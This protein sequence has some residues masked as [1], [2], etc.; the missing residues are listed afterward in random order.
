MVMDCDDIRLH[1]NTH[2]MTMCPGGGTGLAV[3]PRLGV[4]VVAS[5]RHVLRVYKLEGGPEGMPLLD[6]LGHDEE[7]PMH[8]HF[9]PDN[10]SCLAFGPL[11]LEAGQDL[12]LAADFG[13]DTVHIIDVPGRAHMGYVWGRGGI[14]SPRGVAT[15]GAR[16]AV[17]LRHFDAMWVLERQGTGDWVRTHTFPTLEGPRGLRFAADGA[18]IVVAEAGRHRVTKVS[19]PD[20]CM[21]QLGYMIYPTDVLEVSGGW[22][23]TKQGIDPHYTFLPDKNAVSPD[24]PRVARGPDAYI[25]YYPTALAY[26]PRLGLLAVPNGDPH[27][28]HGFSTRDDMAMAS[29][30]QARLA[31]MTTAHRAR[32]RGVQSSEESATPG[33]VREW[34]VVDVTRYLTRRHV[35]KFVVDTLA[36]AGVTGDRLFWLY[37]DAV[38]GKLCSWAG[39]GITARRVQELL[40][41]LS[42]LERRSW[43][44][45]ES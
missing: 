40:G 15:R 10:S 38:D 45:L 5:G 26:A 6:V 8:F 42:W 13:H 4:A 29:M 31:W 17:T 14:P 22:L 44:L 25:G 7:G 20:G 12:L 28:I 9:D 19:L 35:D 41:V 3:S 33:A 2:L 21:T 11:A 34:T 37:W 32:H 39:V 18:H 16:V 24:L 36:C 1:S 30:S 23:V 43:V 27:H